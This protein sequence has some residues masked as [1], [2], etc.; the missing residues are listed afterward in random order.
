MMLVSSWSQ[1]PRQAE[2]QAGTAETQAGTRYDVSMQKF[3]KPAEKEEVIKACMMM[4]GFR[5]G[6]YRF[7]L[8]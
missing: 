5:M 6:T 2:T 7:K 3:D 4:Q 1:R 8:Y